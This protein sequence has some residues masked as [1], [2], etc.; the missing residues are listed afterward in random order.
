MARFSN[1]R[2]K[3]R[4]RKKTSETIIGSLILLVHPVHA[5]D[6]KPNLIRDA[7]AFSSAIHSGTEAEWILHRWETFMSDERCT[8]GESL[9]FFANGNVLREFCSSEGIVTSVS[10]TW[11]LGR[12]DGPNFALTVGEE[13]FEARIRNVEGIFELRLQNEI[14]IKS[15]VTNSNIYVRQE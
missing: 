13:T 6:S 12:N 4:S 5:E 15:D 14:D 9:T 8:T 10:S 11:V 3:I 2:K 1:F 7:D